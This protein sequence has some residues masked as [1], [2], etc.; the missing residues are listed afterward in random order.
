MRA[1]DCRV[2]GNDFLPTD[3]GLQPAARYRL[4]LMRIAMALALLAACFAPRMEG[5]ARPT[6]D[7]SAENA[8]VK[9][10]RAD[11]ALRQSYPLAP[12]A[13]TKLERDPESPLSSEDEKLAAAAGYA[14]AEFHH[15]AAIRQCDWDMSIEDGP[16]AN[17]AHRV[18]IRELAA[19]STLRA[20][21]RFR[22][23]DNPG[24][25]ADVLDAMAAA[26]H[27][28]LDGSIASVLISYKLEN[29]LRGVLA[30]N[31]Y[32]FS[33]AQLNDLARGL[34]AL[35]AG[36]SMGAAFASEKVRRDDLFF[37]GVVQGAKTRDEL[38]ERLV[39][40]VP[41]LESKRELAGKVVDGCGGSLAGFERC[42]DQKRSFYESWAGRFTLPPEQFEA[43]YTAEI[44]K[45]S[46]ENPLIR[47]FT[48]NLGR[49]RWAETYSRTRR[50]LLRAAVAVRLDGPAAL[51]LHPDPY[52]QQPFS[53]VPVDGGFRLES[54]LKEGGV[55]IAFSVTP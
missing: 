28:S 40:K 18:A 34:D 11:A 16:F 50:V 39:A 15:G 43:A 30:R 5:Q 36:S 38:I 13:V 44:E 19:V 27:L 10:L 49:F 3:A 22:D 41:P 14:L 32:R 9:Y 7:P 29:L 33:P 31:L 24:A 55:P 35:P 52:D 8:A 53:Y 20:R 47:E 1:G 6:G 26:R 51:S 42:I 17:T 45:A 54:R 2:F 25:M 48:P 23:G 37:F 46:K 21:L 4:M 12:D